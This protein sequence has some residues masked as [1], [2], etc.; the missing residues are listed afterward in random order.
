MERLY[1]KHVLGEK[2]PEGG[3]VPLTSLAP[4]P[5]APKAAQEEEVGSFGD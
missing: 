5:L 2:Q 4:K 3:F 1:R